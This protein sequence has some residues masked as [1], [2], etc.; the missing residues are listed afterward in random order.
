MS[1][2]DDIVKLIDASRNQLT[3]IYEKLDSNDY[4]KFYKQIWGI[5]ADMEYIV[6]SL[7]LLNDINSVL[8]DEKWKDDFASTLKQVR[9]ERKIRQEFIETIELY[10]SLE[11]INQIMNFYKVCWM[12]KEKLTILLNVAK[13]KHKIE[14]NNIGKIDDNL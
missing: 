14:K 12:I 4:S 13:P 9:A 7:K 6:I 1:L 3:K 11:N 8:T 2:N 5:R 10:R